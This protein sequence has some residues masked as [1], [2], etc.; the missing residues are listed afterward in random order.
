MKKPTTAERY[1]SVFE[2]KAERRT[3][4]AAEGLVEDFVRCAEQGGCPHCDT[5]EA[6]LHGSV[7]W[8]QDRLL[9]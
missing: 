5:N 9:F 1:A 8:E 3:R 7:L 6:H 2:S 4:A